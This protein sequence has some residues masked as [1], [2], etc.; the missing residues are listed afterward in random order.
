MNRPSTHRRD[1]AGAVAVVFALCAVTLFMI[2]GLVVDL[3]LARDTRRGS[4]NAADASA[5][6][7]ANVLYPTNGLCSAGTPPCIADAVAAAKSYAASNF[8]VSGAAWAAGS[9]SDPAHL[10]V[11]ATGTE[12]ISFDSATNPKIVRVTMPVREVRTTFG[13]LAGVSQVPVRAAAEALLGTAVGGPCGLC[14]LGDGLHDFG[15]TNLY[16]EGTSV[17]MNGELCAKKDFTVSPAPP[18]TLEIEDGVKTSNGC[19]STGV[20]PYPVGT[21]AHVDDPFAT[22]AMPS[23]VGL[24]VKSDTQNPCGPGG[25]PGIY[26]NFSSAAN[27]MPGN[28]CTLPKGLYVLADATGLTGNGHD[29]VGDGVTIY[30][31]CGTTTAIAPCTSANSE[32]FTMTSQQVHLNLVAATAANAQGGAV[33]GVAIMADRG[34]TG[35][36]SFQGGGGGGTTQG[37]I[38]L[39]GGTMHYGGNSD[40]AVLDSMIVVKDFAG[41]GNSATLQVTNTGTNLPDA[42]PK[43]PS[44]YK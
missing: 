37:A 32:N 42:G 6:A 23:T 16:A 28:R 14:I 36:I 30:L 33:P 21:G 17:K 29:I 9:C 41:N 38:Y 13:A 39:P 15:T 25:G 5:L 12:C 11:L 40:G 10:A 31:V 22:L 35:T 4:Q 1:E 8:A 19:K 27:T 26:K 18:N 43:T 34:W 20:A 44:L 3:G 7:A 2:A 24:P